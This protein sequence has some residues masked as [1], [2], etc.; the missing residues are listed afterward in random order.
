M[1]VTLV[2]IAAG[3]DK[4]KLSF[5]DYDRSCESVIDCAPVYIGPLGCC[6]APCPNGA[7]RATV[8]E[9]ARKDVEAARECKGPPP[10]CIGPVP[11]LCPDHRVLCTLGRC[12]L[13]M[14]SQDA[15][16]ND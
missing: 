1:L 11:G 7:V 6:D 3:C 8:V 9:Q 14:P 5:S 16:T 13:A 10:P 4:K 2:S 15:A 12:E